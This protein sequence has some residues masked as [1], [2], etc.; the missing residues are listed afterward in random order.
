[1]NIFGGMNHAKY[2]IV[3]A[4]HSVFILE[5]LISS[6]FTEKSVVLHFSGRFIIGAT[7]VHTKF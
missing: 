7:Y 1:M 2:T 6:L 4:E 3:E 5:L